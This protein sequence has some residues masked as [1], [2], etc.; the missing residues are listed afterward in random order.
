MTTY[1]I[2]DGIQNAKLFFDKIDQ[3]DAFLWNTMIW[4]H[5]SFRRYEETLLLI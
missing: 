4:V 3:Q 2:I 5:A 1:S